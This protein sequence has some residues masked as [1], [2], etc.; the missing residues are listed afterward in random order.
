MAL[1]VNAMTT[2]HKDD[3]AG[4]SE[5]KLSTNGTVAFEVALDTSVV[6]LKSDHHADVAL[7]AMEVVDTEALA[8]TTD[9]TVVAM[10]DVLGGVV[11]PE[12]AA[13][14]VVFG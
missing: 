4:A 8:N 12:L 3:R 10:I 1:V 13:V 6:V 9:A 14:A 2:W 11:I 7:V 5:H